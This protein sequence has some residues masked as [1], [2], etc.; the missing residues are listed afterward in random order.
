MK[1]LEMQYEK[2]CVPVKGTLSD[3]GKK[4]LIEDYQEHSRIYFKYQKA[5]GRIEEVSKSPCY[6]DPVI[7]SL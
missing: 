7:P 2:E 4:V 3:D 1:I 5:D 6:I